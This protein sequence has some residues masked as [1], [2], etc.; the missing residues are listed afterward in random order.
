MILSYDTYA[1]NV[2]SD[3]P[4]SH[5]CLSIFRHVSIN[6]CVSEA[7]ITHG[8]YTSHYELKTSLSIN[9]FP[10]KEIFL[11]QMAVTTVEEPMLSRLDRLDNIMRRLEETR[12]GTRTPKSSC[13]STPVS[14]VDLEKQCRPIDDVIVETGMKG[15]L[16]ERLVDVEERVAKLCMQLQLEE[17]KRRVE[18]EKNMKKKN[19][20]LKQ[21]VKACVARNQYKQT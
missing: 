18:D 11:Q 16:I 10:G 14:S 19:R 20:G 5:R 3:S 9:S 2:S 13:A 1:C 8:P 17:E 7:F 15:T 21:L 12:G 4:H 6:N